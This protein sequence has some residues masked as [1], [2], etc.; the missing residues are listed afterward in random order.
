[1][2]K[3]VIA[4][5]KNERKMKEYQQIFGLYGIPVLQKT[6]TEDETTI[7]NWFH[8]SE[9]EVIC[10]FREESNLY[11]QKTGHV[12]EQSHLETVLN[13]AMLNVYTYQGGEIQKQTYYHKVEGYID[14]NKRK[15]QDDVFD[16]DDIFINKHIKWSY[17]ELKEKGLKNSA[18]D[19]VLSQFIRDV[20]YYEERI[21]LAFQ[22]QNQRKSIDFSNRVSDFVKSNAFLNNPYLSQYSLDNVL[23]YVINQGLFF[24]SP[25]NRREKNY[26]LPGLNA[27][28]PLVPK[29]DPIHEI[30][31]MFHDMTHFLM[32]D[33]VY[34]GENSNLH[35]RVYILYRMMSE[36]ISLCMADML[37]VDTLA[38]SGVSYD[39]SKRNIYPMFTDLALDI[40]H[41]FKRD[42]AKL[43]YAN[44]QYA[45]NGDDSYFHA[46][47][48]S[49]DKTNLEKYK[50][51]YERFFVEDYKW[52]A[53]NFENMTMKKENIKRWLTIVKP[54]AELGD[55]SF[56]T[57]SDMIEKLQVEDS[58]SN[59]EI[60]NTLF[61]YV[62]RHIVLPSCQKRDD[63][64]DHEWKRGFFRY[65][66]GQFGL[67]SAFYFLEET[68]QYR[69]L[70]TQY[71]EVHVQEWNLYHIETV[72]SLFEQYIGLL[73]EKQLLSFDDA[74]T[75]KEMYTL[76]PPFY[77][78]YDAKQ[79]KKKYSIT[80]IQTLLL[81]EGE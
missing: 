48:A 76:F 71:M 34:D 40:K 39:F 15:E 54:I 6:R 67:F 35:K 18:R 64:T 50:E 23:S 41:H 79:E 70:I 77:V 36:A 7:Q 61:Q 32:P 22:P 45:C 72:L 1:M 13:K 21:D 42:V 59:E 63:N 56:L 3:V 66:M 74:E 75:Y 73:H 14:R 52:T 31:F 49:E 5:T 12:S 2:K 62:Y 8:S 9:V 11:N 44:V 24:K 19:M 33:L 57:V 60:L 20:L 29:K 30:T 65:M 81:S 80:E 16:W 69:E 46:L 68:K 58:C 55:I 37:F 25:K 4:M 53:K 17:H 51:K 47:Y 10:V 28:L 27:G 26:W 38:S 43:L 78:F